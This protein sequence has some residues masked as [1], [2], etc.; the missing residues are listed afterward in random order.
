ME[1]KNTI[2]VVVTWDN[3][4]ARLTSKKSVKT[5]QDAKEEVKSWY[6]LTLEEY[7]NDDKGYYA[8]GTLDDDCLFAIIDNYRRYESCEA[9]EVEI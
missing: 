9:F 8:A 3:E 4:S 1:K 5:E 7:N 2:W 6:N